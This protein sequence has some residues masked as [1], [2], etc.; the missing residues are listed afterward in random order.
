MLDF[1]YY[2]LWIMMIGYVYGDPKTGIKHQKSLILIAQNITMKVVSSEVE[3]SLM[4]FLNRN[5]NYKPQRA[6]PRRIHRL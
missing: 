2:P 1:S 4:V 3:K 5:K 6:L